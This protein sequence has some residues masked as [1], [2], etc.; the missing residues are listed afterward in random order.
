[1]KFFSLCSQACNFWLRTL[2][3]MNSRQ[4]I[5]VAI[6]GAVALEVDALLERLESFRSVAWKDGLFHIGSLAKRSVLVGKTGLGKVNAAITTAVLLEAFTIGQVW[7][8]GCAGGFGDGPL[9][10]G[11]VLITR[12]FLCGDEGVLT[13]TGLLSSKE[14]SIPI[15]ERR[16]VQLFDRIPVDRDPVAL[17]FCEKTPEG[18]YQLAQGPPP[19]PALP[20]TASE[21]G[22]FPSFRL[23]L[24]PSLTVGM[25]SGDG[26]T[27]RSRFRHYGAYAENMEGSA[28]AQAC[29]RFATPMLEC[30]GI[31]NQAGNRRKEEWQLEKAV[32]NCQGIILNWLQT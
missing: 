29:F 26:E 9:R 6:L 21:E 24:G 23:L 12:E 11:D 17:D 15:L 16:G 13:R 28:V 7:N 25:A 32:A 3:A 10:V 31:S 1:M 20:K 2:Y 14:I 5:D 8:I 27:A 22:D 19:S 30:R 18:R 4:I